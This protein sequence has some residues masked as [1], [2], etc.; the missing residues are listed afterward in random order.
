[1]KNFIFVNQ[2]QKVYFETYSLVWNV[3]EASLYV[4]DYVLRRI[5]LEKIQT[6]Q[7]LQILLD[8]SVLGQ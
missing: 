4:V 1:M 8:A 6:N 2:A 5:T 3:F 7:D